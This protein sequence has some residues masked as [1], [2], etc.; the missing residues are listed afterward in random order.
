M[1][2]IPSRALNG[3]FC[4]TVGTQIFYE[5]IYEVMTKKPTFRFLLKTFVFSHIFQKQDFEK[6]ISRPIGP[7]Y[8]IYAE[9]TGMIKK[10]GFLKFSQ[11][12]FENL[13]VYSLGTTY[14]KI[15]NLSQ[16]TCSQEHFE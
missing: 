10:I 6:K 2:K 14:S 11:N 3:T 9:H 15:S 4:Y 1:Q 8:K 5:K 16:K 7:F 13:N 12:F